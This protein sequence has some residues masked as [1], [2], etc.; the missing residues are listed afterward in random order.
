MKKNIKPL[1][2]TCA[3][4]LITFAAAAQ[5]TK[6]TASISPMLRLDKQALEKHVEAID[7]LARLKLGNQVHG[8]LTDLELLQRII[9]ERLIASDDSALM[10]SAGVVL[11]NVLA[12]ELGLKWMV[13][14][15]RLGR[16]RAICVNDSSNCL[17]PVTM[18]S[19]RLEVNA[20]V[21]VQKIYNDAVATIDPFIPDNNAYDGK[22]A[23]PKKDP[24]WSA[25]KKKP[26]NKIRIR[27]Y[28]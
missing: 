12:N 16:S 17:F 8:D 24:G 1:L 3:S 28:P 25:I 27:T 23:E 18:L 7:T 13:Y 21:D 15:D 6:P 5:E 22:K 11:G 20:P 10:Q 9:N 14:E 4:L 2:L 19:R 26:D